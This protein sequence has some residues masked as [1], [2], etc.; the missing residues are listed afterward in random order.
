MG[1][2]DAVGGVTDA[3]GVTQHGEKD[4]ARSNRRRQQA[5]Y[6][7][8]FRQQ[9]GFY[10]QAQNQLQKALSGVQSGYGT[11]RANAG[12]SAQNARQ[13]VMDREKQSMG[14]LS[15][16]LAS[17]GLGSTTLLDNARRGLSS[18]TS[19]E[20]SN[21]DA[22]L[23]QVLGQLDIGQA[24]AEAGAR[25]DLAAL[26]QNQAGANT[27]LGVNQIDTMYGSGAQPYVS[28]MAPGGAQQGLQS[29]LALFG[30]GF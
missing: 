19:R 17:R 10:G 30:G 5:L 29:L 21:I 26:F 6:E 1:C 28:T 11:A 14:T 2:G 15:Q 9:G 20:L 12:L 24:M 25:G 27:A 7:Q 13:G 3:L 4:R 23:G 8:F 22:L 18:S 16:S